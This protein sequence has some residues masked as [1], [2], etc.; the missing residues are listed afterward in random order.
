MLLELSMLLL[1]E[2]FNGFYNYWEL[3]WKTF[4][5]D[6]LNSLVN[7]IIMDEFYPKLW[8]GANSKVRFPKLSTR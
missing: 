6:M 2:I 5:Q 1:H 8:E 3:K 4:G 7:C